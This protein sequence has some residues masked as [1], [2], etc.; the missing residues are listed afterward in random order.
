MKEHFNSFD[1]INFFHTFSKI[2]QYL[3]IITL[4]KI[5]RFIQN[6]MPYK[7]I[8][9]LTRKFVF[10]NFHFSRFV[11]IFA[12]CTIFNVLC[13]FQRKKNA[14]LRGT[15]SDWFFFL[16]VFDSQ[17]I[18]TRAPKPNIPARILILLL[19]LA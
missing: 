1:D 3:R 15:R 18:R 11:N 9:R 13:R 19:L 14:R 8:Y 16:R 5:Q 6:F 7:M 4:S 10:L 17:R 2:S 12:Q